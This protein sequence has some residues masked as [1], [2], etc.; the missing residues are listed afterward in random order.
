MRLQLILKK[1]EKSIFVDFKRKGKKLYTRLILFLVTTIKTIIALL[2]RILSSSSQLVTY[3][4]LWLGSV[5]EGV[6][7][8][9][10]TR[11]FSFWWDLTFASAVIGSLCGRT[12][13]RRQLVF[14]KKNH[15]FS[16]LYFEWA[17]SCEVRTNFLEKKCSKLYFTLSTKRSTYYKKL[18]CIPFVT[19]YVLLVGF[20][21][22][23]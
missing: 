23:N 2:L 16:T 11:T 13:L 15:L 1:K 5:K 22:R 19:S 4:S 3:S 21:D 20:V 17:F 14:K 6:F 12:F 18:Y 7:F 10:F 9:C 8:H